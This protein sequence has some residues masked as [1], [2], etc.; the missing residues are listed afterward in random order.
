MNSDAQT[1]DQSKQAL[2]DLRRENFNLIAENRRL[3]LENQMLKTTSDGG[4]Q[5]NR[6]RAFYEEQMREK[7][8]HADSLKDR[9]IKKEQEIS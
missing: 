4:E 1:P 8:S 7:D 2:F 6:E 9:L 5:R 3:E